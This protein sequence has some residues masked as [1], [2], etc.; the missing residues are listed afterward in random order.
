VELVVLVAEEMVVIGMQVGL[1][2]KREILE[3]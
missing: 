2:H 3:L 1:G